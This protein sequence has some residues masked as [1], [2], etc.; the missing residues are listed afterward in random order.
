MHI[1]IMYTPRRTYYYYSNSCNIILSS[2][3]SYM[4]YTPIS[5]FAHL[6]PHRQIRTYYTRYTVCTAVMLIRITDTRSR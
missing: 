2:Y 1:I 3:G 5:I 6:P 4:Y